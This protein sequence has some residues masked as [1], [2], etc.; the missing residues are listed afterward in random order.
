MTTLNTTQLCLTDRQVTILGIALTNLYDEIAKSGDGTK[1]RDDIMI[2]SA[3]VQQQY[4]EYH[5]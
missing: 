5:Q 3:Y 4:K 2:L 1:M